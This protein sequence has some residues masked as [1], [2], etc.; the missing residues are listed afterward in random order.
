[1]L[2]ATISIIAFKVTYLSMLTIALRLCPDLDERQFWMSKATWPVD[3]QPTFMTH[4]AT[5]GAAHYLYLST[6]G[7]EESHPSCAFYPL[8]P[9]LL[10]WFCRLTHFDVVWMG[11]I[12]TNVA[13]TIAFVIFYQIITMR[14]GERIGV[15]SLLLILLYPG[16]LFY[17]F[18]YSESLF[19]LLSMLLLLGMERN[20]HSVIW[21]AG[22]LLPMT[23]AVG[24]FSL[25]P[26]LWYCAQYCAIISS[27]GNRT[28]QLA[29]VSWN[30]L[31]WKE[32]N[33]KLFYK[34][35]SFSRHILLLPCAPLL[36][37]CT[38]FILMWKWTGNPLEGIQAQRFWG[39]VHSI[40]NL[41]NIEKFAL[42]FCSPSAWHDF[43]ES[44][45]DRMVFILFAGCLPRIWA[46][47]KGWFLW[48]LFLGVV[49]AM[50]GTFTS[51]TR[52]ASV[53]FPIFVALATFI[54]PYKTPLVRYV[55][56]G[57]FGL[58]QIVLV[59]RFVNFRWA[60]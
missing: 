53:I 31:E 26:L 23:R 47:D 56:F 48:A 1:M 41:W 15:F 28:K 43:R 13:S 8:W 6:I 4:F 57:L 22:F 32:S 33:L 52:F 19:F 44:M 46:L 30:W 51:F 49:P 10:R 42:G 58:L 55:L 59:W 27:A 12:L 16:A 7:Y 11:L 5:W 29:P 45:L 17:N 60:G 20:W 18:I 37:Y 2:I 35:H 25:A 54:A 9:L 24:I 34:H 50:S 39:H 38:Y 3:S 21:L 36:G 40:G 14:Y